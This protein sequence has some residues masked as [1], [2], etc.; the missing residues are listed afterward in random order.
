MSTELYSI[1]VQIMEVQRVMGSYS[2]QIGN[3]R[4]NI[5]RLEEAYNQLNMVKDDFYD[6][7]D[8]CTKPEFTKRS[9]YGSNERDLTS[10]REDILRPAFTSIPEVQVTGA[11]EKIREK[12][13]F[14]NRK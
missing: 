11:E 4:E 3:H 9:L 5:E 6:S 14:S 13:N 10:L 2:M 1:N 7:E 12:F 8:K